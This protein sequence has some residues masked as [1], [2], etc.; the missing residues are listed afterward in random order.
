MAWAWFRANCDAVLARTLV[1][2]SENEARDVIGSA[3]LLAFEDSDPNRPIIIGLI[4]DRLISGAHHTNSPSREVL[5]NGKRVVVHA[6]QE[7][8]LRCGESSLS[9][10]KSG[11]IV[12]RGVNVVSRAAQTNKVKGASV[13]IN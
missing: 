9:L 1:T 3:V 10:D 13:H 7:L 2:I 12:L 6:D 11:R 5:V 4:R 8:L